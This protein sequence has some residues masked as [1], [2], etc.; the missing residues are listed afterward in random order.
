M[1]DAVDVIT[2]SRFRATDL[3][4]TTKADD[5]HW[6]EADT[7]ADNTRPKLTADPRPD[8][9]VVGE[10]E[11]LVGDPD[12][13]WQWVLE[14]IDGTA[15]YVPGVASWAALIALRQREEAVVGLVSAPALR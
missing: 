13:K 12:A 7:G 3:V 6:A 1:A 5:T 2:A 15:N 9:A 4:V 11:G 8:H 14:P 10:E